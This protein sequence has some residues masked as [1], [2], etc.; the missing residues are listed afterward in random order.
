MLLLLRVR[1]LS[2]V[3]ELT[4][5]QLSLMVRGLHLELHL[6][7]LLN[8]SGSLCLELFHLHLVVLF[9]LL[10]L[11]VVLVGLLG[12]NLATCEL[13]GVLLLHSLDLLLHERDDLNLLCE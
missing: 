3:A 5:H 4:F 10:K 12:L 2:N 9:G 13:L 11:L 8:Q 7:D 6:V 1:Y